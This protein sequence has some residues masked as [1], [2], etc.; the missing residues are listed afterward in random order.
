MVAPCAAATLISI[1]RGALLFTAAAPSSSPFQTG[2][3]A[4]VAVLVAASSAFGAALLARAPLGLGARASGCAAMLLATAA[5]FLA[6]A[7]LERGAAWRELR[8]PSG[9]LRADW[10]GPVEFTEREA[11]G[12]GGGS[13]LREATVRAGGVVYH[14]QE[15]EE[16]ASREDVASRDTR[17]TRDTRGNRASDEAGALLARTRAELVAGGALVLGELRERAGLWLTLRADGRRFRAR[18]LAR[19]PLLFVA[20]AG[21]EGTDDAAIARFLGSLRAPDPGEP[22]PGAKSG[23]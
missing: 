10:P 13:I 5:T 9:K 8:T 23:R 14:L 18:L 12:P 1:D 7:P 11:P 3:L 17:D 21:P 6:S 16:R 2:V 4:M 15:R 22:A 20:S 19:P